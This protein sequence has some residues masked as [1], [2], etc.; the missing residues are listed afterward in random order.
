MA[1]SPFE[2]KPGVAGGT[3]VSAARLN[4]ME[5]GIGDIAVLAD[6]LAEQIETIVAGSTQF[7]NVLD[8]GAVG[9]GLTDDAPA[10]QAAL[11]AA[12][13]VG[14]AHVLIP[15]G[16]TYAIRTFLCVFDNTTVSAYGAKIISL[17]GT[18]LIR[19]F[20]AGEHAPEYFGHSHI[21]ILGGVWD[22][23][24][25]NGVD[26]TTTGI[27]TAFNFV[28]CRDITVRDVTIRNVSTSHAIEFNSTDGGRALNCRF[29]GFRDNTS[30]QS[31]QYSEAVQIDCALNII[32]TPADL[33]PSRN[34]VIDGCYTGPSER[35]GPYG[36]LVG[37]HTGV[38]GQGVIYDGITI[39]NCEADDTLSGAISGYGW[40]NV[41]IANNRLNS[42]AIDPSIRLVVP[43]SATW[44]YNLL[45]DSI[46]IQGNTVRDSGSGGI[47]VRGDPNAKTTGVIISANRVLNAGGNG[48]HVWDCDA[49]IVQSNQVV[50]ITG[51]GIMV[52][53]S[54]RANVS[55]NYVRGSSS[56]GI[57]INGSSFTLTEGNKVYA[58]LSNYCYFSGPSS[59]N[60][61]AVSGAF[62]S[63]YAEAGPT[64]GFRLSNNSTGFSVMNNKI[65]KGA[66]GNIGIS[67]HASSTGCSIVGNDLGGNGWTVAQAL[68][69]STSTPKMDYAGGTT[70]PGHNLVS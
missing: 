20:L 3:I 21:T 24:A 9:D 14:G 26:G 31:R 12:D 48:I 64:A 30:D 67:M 19:N 40:Q 15:G 59:D 52:E 57:N 69:L 53:R 6:D 38:T 41:I 58:P 8:Y 32:I 68:T 23:N 18:G 22:E 60:T 45:V 7:F 36:R 2:W 27:P 16:R 65:V 56:N 11:N 28:H 54:D 4:H 50:N 34:I 5:N 1:Y 70:S 39:V 66:G 49:P 42:S 55:T 35:C 25:F 33:T 47:L 37:S 43:L 29:E 51:Q 62:L 10:I 44:G 17:G 46:I 63:N 13:A 61:N